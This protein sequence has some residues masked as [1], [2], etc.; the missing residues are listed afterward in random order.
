MFETI[1]QFYDKHLWTKKMVGNAVEKGLIT[2]EQYEDI[3]GNKFIQ[4]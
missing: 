4:E 2:S 1:K 3:T